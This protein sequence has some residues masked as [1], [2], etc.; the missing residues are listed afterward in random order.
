[1]RDDRPGDGERDIF[2]P[3]AADRVGSR[4]GRFARRCMAGLEGLAHH[5]A[6][7]EAARS[8][9]AE[10]CPMAEATASGR[11][12]APSRASGLPWSRVLETGFQRLVRPLLVRA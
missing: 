1:G 4:P 12:R 11:R 10:D 7:A 2:Y 5:D 3:G 9:R 8:R 6:A